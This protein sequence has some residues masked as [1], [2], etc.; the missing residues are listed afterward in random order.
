MTCWNALSFFKEFNCHIWELVQLT[1]TRLILET[2]TSHLPDSEGAT[3][4]GNAGTDHSQGY[5]VH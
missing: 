4:S 5:Q 1:K 3:G 2:I